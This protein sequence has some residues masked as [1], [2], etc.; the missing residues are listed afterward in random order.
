M[1]SRVSGEENFSSTRVAV[2]IFCPFISFLVIGLF[3]LFFV[4]LVYVGD[5]DVN[6]WLG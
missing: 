6:D 3:I 2:S 1:E 5:G 4:G